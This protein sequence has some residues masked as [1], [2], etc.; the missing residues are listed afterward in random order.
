MRSQQETIGNT[1]RSAP[2]ACVLRLNYFYSFIF[3]FPGLKARLRKVE[4]S[5]ICMVPRTI[6]VK[7]LPF[8]WGD[9]NVGVPSRGW[10]HP[11][12][13]YQTLTHL[14]MLQY[15]LGVYRG[16]RSWTR[17]ISQPLVGRVASA[18]SALSKNQYTCI[19]G[20]GGGGRPPPR[21]GSARLHHRFSKKYRYL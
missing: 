6:H 19:W 20:V 18:P 5:V 15:A 16:Y 21:F 11:M 10:T 13:D 12:I 17:T 4:K 14:N 1:I 2:A 3:I 7:L 9:G 8:W